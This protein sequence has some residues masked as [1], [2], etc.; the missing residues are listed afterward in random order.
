MLSSFFF[1]S[2]YST[3]TQTFALASPLWKQGR[4]TSNFN[5]TL[6]MVTIRG[7]LLFSAISKLGLLGHQTFLVM[8]ADT[9]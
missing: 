9:L 6:R 7:R 1:V 3:F 4:S 8:A 5:P 2:S